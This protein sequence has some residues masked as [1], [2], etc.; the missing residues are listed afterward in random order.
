MDSDSQPFIPYVILRLVHAGHLTSSKPNPS[1][2]IIE[3]KVMIL[4][5]TG[6][7]VAAMEHES[8]QSVIDPDVKLR[9]P[10][11]TGFRCKLRWKTLLGMIP[12]E[13]ILHFTNLERHRISTHN[14]IFQLKLL[15]VALAAV[16]S[17]Q[18]LWVGG[19]SQEACCYHVDW[20]NSYQP[21]THPKPYSL[22]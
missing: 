20:Q 6:A 14:F 8:S 21:K 19:P 3:L 17:V 7:G 2:D 11:K 5:V 4:G 18:K 13:T 9:R 16:P 22:V 12:C 1:V 10:T 15:G